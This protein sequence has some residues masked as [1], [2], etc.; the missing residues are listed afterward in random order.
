MSRGRNVGER[1]HTDLMLL[2]HRA[3]LQEW[4]P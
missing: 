4:C 3:R 2:D 1:E